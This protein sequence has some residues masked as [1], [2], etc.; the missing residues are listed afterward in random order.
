M[1]SRPSEVR[2][3]M[4]RLRMLNQT[5][6]LLLTGTT[7]PGVNVCFQ[8]CKHVTWQAGTWQQQPSNSHYGAAAGSL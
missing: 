1:G 8:A 4:N 5:F 6:N 2:L 7:N 3:S